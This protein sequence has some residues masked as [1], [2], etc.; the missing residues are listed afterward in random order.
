MIWLQITHQRNYDYNLL[1]I[2]VSNKVQW[3]LFFQDLSKLS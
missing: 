1:E 2:V 3:V